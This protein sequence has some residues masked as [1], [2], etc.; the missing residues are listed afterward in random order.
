MKDLVKKAQAANKPAAKPAAKKAV[1]THATVGKAKYA[2]LQKNHA[3]MR[4]Y[5]IAAAIVCGM[6]TV[7]KTGAPRALK[8]GD[9]KRWSKTVGRAASNWRTTKRVDENGLTTLGLNTVQASLAGEAKGYS[10]TLET[11][12]AFTA[13]LKKGG[14][15]KVDDIAYQLKALTL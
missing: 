2:D 10:T 9:V 3:H 12:N 6:L 13:G 1:T 8:T 7:S 4:A 5:T 15:V 11:V 14:E